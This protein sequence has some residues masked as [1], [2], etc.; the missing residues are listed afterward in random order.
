MPF[1]DVHNATL[2]LQMALSSLRRN[3]HMDA[4]CASFPIHRDGTCTRYCGRTHVVIDNRVSS[5]YN[6]A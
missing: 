5:A 6:T 3:V 4:L 2:N 1:I